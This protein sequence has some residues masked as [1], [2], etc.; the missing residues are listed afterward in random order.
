MKNNK[1][2]QELRE[3][4]VKLKN[5][6]SEKLDCYNNVA[7]IDGNERKFSYY[8]TF[9]KNQALSQIAAFDAV[10]NAIDKRLL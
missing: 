9:R 1:A 10:L 5:G 6:E 2:L 8:D 4:V 3:L 7:G